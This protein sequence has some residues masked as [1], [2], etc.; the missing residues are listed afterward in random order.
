MKEND[1]RE[2]LLRNQINF[3]QHGTIW[4]TVIPNVGAYQN[5]FGQMMHTMKDHILHINNEGIA[6]LA[7]DDMNGL[8]K[9]STLVFL[10]RENIQKTD[11]QIKLSKF[12]LMITTDKG[13]LRYKIRRHILACPWHKEN[14]SFLLLRS[15][16]Q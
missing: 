16:T 12:I 14:L 1:I 6:I 15:A 9:E 7:V 8:P 11:I 2:I 13:E 5:G 4:G 3:A 10:S